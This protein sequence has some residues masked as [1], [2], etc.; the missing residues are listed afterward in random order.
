MESEM[1]LIDKV[2]RRAEKD[3]TDEILKILQDVMMTLNALGIRD[4][5]DRI[6]GWAQDLKQAIILMKKSD[7]ND[8]E[9][10]RLIGDVMRYLGGIGIRDNNKR[11]TGLSND[12][13]RA[14]GLMRDYRKGAG[15]KAQGR[16]YDVSEWKEFMLEGEFDGE[17]QAIEGGEGSYEVPKEDRDAAAE[18]VMQNSDAFDDKINW[19]DIEAE[20]D[21]YESALFNA[22]TEWVKDHPLAEGYTDEDLMTDDTLADVYFTLQGAG[23]G[24]WDGRWDEYFTNEKD[25]EEIEKFLELKLR[26][27]CDGTGGG[28]LSEA[29]SVA[30]YEYFQLLIN[31]YLEGEG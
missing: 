9:A 6:E 31:E 21:K 22:I 1:N 20:A 17:Y 5:N 28:S 4:Q 7:E 12:L 16:H 29:F 10:Y 13:Q 19:T 18:Y 25:L 14:M 15:K 23:V 3:P 2:I 30:T 11:L 8:P 27:F 24:I 26:G